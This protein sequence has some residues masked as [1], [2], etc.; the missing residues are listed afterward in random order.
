M[1]ADAVAIGSCVRCHCTHD[2]ACAGGCAW[3]AHDKKRELGVWLR[4]IAAELR[5]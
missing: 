5:R 2:R 3:L 4:A 1:R